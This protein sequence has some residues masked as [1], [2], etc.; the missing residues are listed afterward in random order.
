[1]RER[2]GVRAERQLVG[3]AAREV[4]ERPRRQAPLGLALEVRDVDQV[5]HDYPGSRM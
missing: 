3:R 5:V 1:M 4:P 2:A